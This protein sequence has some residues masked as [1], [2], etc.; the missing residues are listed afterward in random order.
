MKT[1]FSIGSLVAFVVDQGV[2]IN[3]VSAWRKMVGQSFADIE[4]IMTGVGNVSLWLSPV[5][6]MPRLVFVWIM[7]SYGYV[8][9]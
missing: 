7:R 2:T 9:I 3:G 6:S 4:L 1:I 8:I 5:P